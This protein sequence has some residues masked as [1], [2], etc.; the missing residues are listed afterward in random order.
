MAVLIGHRGERE[1]LRGV[2]LRNV[3]ARAYRVR[4][5]VFGGE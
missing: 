1:Y 3:Q 4:K 5:P 2:S